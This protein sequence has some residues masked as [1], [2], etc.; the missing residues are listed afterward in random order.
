MVAAAGDAERFYRDRLRGR[1]RERGP[2]GGQGQD[3]GLPPLAISA[4]GKGVAMLPE[5][6]RRRTRA[7]EQRVRTFGKRAGTGEKKGCKRMAETGAVFDVVPQEPR[8][9]E[10]V[11]R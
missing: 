9:P 3:R 8:T 11:M 6:R 5:A 10:Q 4:D 1:E 2:A 7:P